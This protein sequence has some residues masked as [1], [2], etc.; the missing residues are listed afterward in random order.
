MRDLDFHPLTHQFPKLQ[1]DAYRA[2]VG[3]IERRGLRRP[4]ALF[5]GKIW[6]GRARYDACDE[7]GIEPKFRV[8]QRNDQ[9]IDY[10]IVRSRDQKYGSPKSPEREAALKILHRMHDPDYLAEYKERRASWISKARSEFK[11]Q[12]GRVQNCAVCQKHAEFVHAHHTLPLNI[13]FDLGLDEADHAHDWLCP[14]HHRHVHMMISVYITETR[15]G[16]FL[17]C[18]PDD[19]A[20]D[21]LAVERLYERTSALLK[22]YGG[23]AGFWRGHDYAEQD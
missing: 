8:L 18:I 9:P 21:W 23:A 1:G 10:L 12:V 15:D 16:A 4:I 11:W 3:D 13:Q 19:L 17:D 22:I 7:L 14:T 6:D 5:E 2:F 20:K